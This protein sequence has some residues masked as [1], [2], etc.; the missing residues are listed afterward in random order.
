MFTDFL[1]ENLITILVTVIAINTATLAVLNAKMEDICHRN[2]T[3]MKAAFGNS[4]EQMKLSILEMVAL[5]MVAVVLFIFMNGKVELYR[6]DIII[7]AIHV[8]FFSIFVY[9]VFVLYDT[10]ISIFSIHK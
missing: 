1:K 2:N 4:L 5:V 8:L 7:P 10:A 3:T 9:A 6:P